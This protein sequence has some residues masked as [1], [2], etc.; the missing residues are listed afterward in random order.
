VTDA[1]PYFLTAAL[2]VYTRYEIRGLRRENADLRRQLAALRGG[3]AVVVVLLLPGGGRAEVK[4]QDRETPT[5]QLVLALTDLTVKVRPEE[6]PF[7]VYV[8]FAWSPPGV[9]RAE[10]RR[11]FR[12]EINKRNGGTVVVPEVEVDGPR[13]TVATT[14]ECTLIRFFTTDCPNWTRTAW[15]LVADR[16]YLFREAP[17]G[18]LPHRETHYGR[19]VCGIA[20]NEKTLAAGY[21]VNASQLYRDMMELDRSQT[22]HDL[23]YAAERHPDPDG[24]KVEFVAVTNPAEAV[25]VDP[26][27]E[28]KKPPVRSW[29][30]GYWPAVPNWTVTDHLMAGHKWYPRGEFEYYDEDAMKAYQRD[31]ARWKEAKAAWDKAPKGKAAKGVPFVPK[32]PISVKDA[33]QG[34]ADFPATLIDFQARWGGRKREEKLKLF[35][36]DPAVGGIALGADSGPEG[37]TVAAGGDRVVKVEGTEFGWLGTTYDS[38]EAVDDKD[39]IERDQFLNITKGIIQFDGGEALA[40]LPLGGQAEFLFDGQERSVTIANTKLAKHLE[41]KSTDPRYP[42]VRVGYCAACHIQTAGF[43][44]FVEQFAD[45]RA[46]GIR[47]NVPIEDRPAADQFYSGFQRKVKRWRLPYEEFIDLTTADVTG[48]PWTGTQTWEA[49]RKVRDAYD[50]PIGIAEAAREFGYPVE[51]FRALLLQ[52]HEGK[53]AIDVRLNQLATGKLVPRITWQKNVAQKAA[54]WLDLVAPKREGIKEA[55]APQILDDAIKRF[56]TKVT[57]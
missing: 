29:P 43:N 26:G 56:G 32:R 51:D 42:D 15:R 30:G 17:L 11:A 23:L 20:Q 2:Y 37:S 8:S 18:T 57:K 1:L 21:I 40:S 34:K 38:F 41:V 3:G 44:A 25:P 4:A 13:G 53:G 45:S 27:P 9:T 19:I 48:K 50:R 39:Q 5:G 24:G 35:L 16:D 55:L 52:E 36:F 31:H 7:A 6:A 14:P 33:G 46:R 10:F 28:P 47:F 22:G 54:L 49:V 12:H